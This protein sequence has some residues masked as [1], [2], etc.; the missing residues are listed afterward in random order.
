MLDN[1]SI[2]GISGVLAGSGWQVFSYPQNMPNWVGMAKDMPLTDY[3]SCGGGTHLDGTNYGINFQPCKLFYYDAYP[4]N[5]LHRAA[6][7]LK[8]NNVYWS[9][10]LQNSTPIYVSVYAHSTNPK[11]CRWSGTYGEVY[12]LDE[13]MGLGTFYNGAPA[14]YYPLFH[15]SVLQDDQ[16]APVSQH[17][18]H[19]LDS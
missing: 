15:R 10:A 3:D 18:I 14:L 4:T 8:F 5:E 12:M 17:T 7:V 2:Y 13:S 6:F 9:D 16:S 19:L 11:T 1:L